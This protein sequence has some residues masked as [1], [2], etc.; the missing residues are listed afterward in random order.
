MPEGLTARSYIAET[1]REMFSE[2]IGEPLDQATQSELE[3][4]ILYM[5]F[6]NTQVWIGYNGNIVYRFLPNGDD[7]NSC[8][9]ETMILMRHPKGTVPLG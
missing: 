6:P 3:D 1:N 5:L 7:H 4:A 8:I 2:L 9:F